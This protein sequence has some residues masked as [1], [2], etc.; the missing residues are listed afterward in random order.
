MRQGNANTTQDDRRK[1]RSPN[2]DCGRGWII[3]LPDEER[4]I[5]RLVGTLPP[6]PPP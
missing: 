1:K 5:E 4:D 3:A 2:R 6:L